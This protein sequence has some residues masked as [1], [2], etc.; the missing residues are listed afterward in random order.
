MKRLIPEYLENAT[1]YPPGRPLEEV[2]RMH[3]ITELTKLN[4]NE[5]CLGP[6]PLAIQAV[7]ESAGDIHLYPDNSAF[8]LKRK[9]ADKWNIS[10]EQILLGNGSNEL[11]QFIL[12]TFLLPGEEVITAK[13]TFLLY[14][15]MG[16]VLGGRVKEV[17]LNNF[18]YDL[19]RMTDELTE[20]TKLIFISNPNNPTG[21]IVTGD[22]FE[23]F[24]GH[25]PQDVVVVTDEAYGEYVTSTDFP[26]TRD[27]VQKG[28]NV[29]VLRTFSKAYGLAGLRLG[30]AIA[31]VRIIRYMEKIRE[32]FNANSLAQKA[33][34]AAL[35]DAA[36]VTK[37]RENNISGLAYLAAELQRL[38]VS[39]VPSQANFILIDLGPRA[40]EVNGMLLQEGVMVRSMSGYGLQECLRVTIGLPEENRKFIDTLERVLQRE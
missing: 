17:P 12:M 38:Q 15:I 27:Y 35:D 8:Y 16:H 7:R 6:S 11:V 18:A 32:P 33:A 31:P 39:Y 10:A 9:L 3:G 4:A 30:Y 25:V 2:T 26:D 13:P 23:R 14:G 34:L 29:I 20:K 24:M 19:E 22:E 21:T 5:N 1:L 28:R 37:T 40:E 36:H